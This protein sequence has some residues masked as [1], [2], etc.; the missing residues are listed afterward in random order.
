[1]AFIQQC[2]YHEDESW[3]GH[4]EQWESLHRLRQLREDVVPYSEYEVGQ[5]EWEEDPDLNRCELECGRVRND[6]H[7]KVEAQSEDGSTVTLISFFLKDVELKVFDIDVGYLLENIDSDRVEKELY[8]G[9]RNE[10][11]HHTAFLVWV[12]RIAPSHRCCTE[13]EE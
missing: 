3:G 1:M 7:E 4:V 5:V 13:L 12:E 11:H 6:D 2:Y 9:M 10:R 8:N